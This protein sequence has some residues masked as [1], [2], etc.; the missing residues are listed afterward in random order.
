[1]WNRISNV[2]LEEFGVVVSMEDNSSTKT[3][4]FSSCWSAQ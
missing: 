3:L 2:T 4:I 1:L